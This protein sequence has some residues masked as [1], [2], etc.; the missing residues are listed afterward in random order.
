MVEKFGCVPSDIIAGI[1]DLIGTALCSKSRNRTFG[2]YLGHGVRASEAIKKMKQTVE[3]YEATKCLIALA[4]KY[5]VDTPFAYTIYACLE[6]KD[7]RLVFKRF[8][9]R[10]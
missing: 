5:K 8:L 9:E 2:E 10:M 4:K 1:G 6:A 7:P 3:G